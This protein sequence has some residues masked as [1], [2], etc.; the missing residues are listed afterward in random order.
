[1]LSKTIQNN[2]INDYKKNYL[3]EYLKQ[4]HIDFKILNRNKKQYCFPKIDKSY[5]FI[6]INYHN[7]TKKSYENK[8]NTFKI[9]QTKLKNI[10]DFLKQNNINFEYAQGEYNSNLSANISNLTI[11][12]NIVIPLNKSI[13]I[14]ETEL[15]L[16]KNDFYE[17]H[18][19][20]E[21]EKF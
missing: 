2:F 7:F 14:Y 11:N 16:K 5:R 19:L 6:K 13:K 3:I 20:K 15:I 18:F 9:C 10:Y 8:K 4:N 21:V 12:C 1:M 17:N